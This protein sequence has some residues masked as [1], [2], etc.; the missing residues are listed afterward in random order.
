LKRLDIEIE[1]AKDQRQY[2]LIFDKSKNA[3]VYFTYKGLLKDFHK[4]VVACT[5]GKKLRPDALENLRR[6]L[7]YGMRTGDT[8]V[9]FVDKTMPDFSKEY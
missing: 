4:D 6:G 8:L 2:C 7:V 5:A 1:L 3:N 9:I